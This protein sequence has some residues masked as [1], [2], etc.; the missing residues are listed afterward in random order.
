M[1][2]SE[3]DF[4]DLIVKGT[5]E[6]GK[7]VNP[8]P[9]TASN[10]TIDRRPGEDRKVTI[11]VDNEKVSFTIDIEPRKVVALELLSP[12]DVINY[13]VGE[14]FNKIGMA[15][16]YRFNSGE[17]V[18][19]MDLYL[20]DSCFSGFDSRTPV[21]CQIV[22]YRVDDASVSFTVNVQEYK[23]MGLRIDRLPY[24]E[25]FY[26]Y[27]ELSLEGMKIT[28]LMPYGEERDMEYV[29]WE[30][31]GF[32]SRKP[33][34]DQE[35]T[36]RI[37]DRTVSFTVDILPPVE[38]KSLTF[39]D[40]IKEE[41][42][43][44]E[45]LDMMYHDLGATYTGYAYNPVTN[46]VELREFGVN[47][48]PTA[49]EIS[50]FDSSQP[51]DNQVLSFTFGGLTATQTIDIV[52][53]ELLSLRVIPSKPTYYT[54]DVL[55]PEELTVLCTYENGYIRTMPAG[56]YL[57]SGFDSTKPVQDQRVTVSYKGQSD[58]FFIQVLPLELKSIS[59]NPGLTNYYLGEQFNRSMLRVSA[60]YNS[61][62]IK[63]VSPELV[64][65][66][67]FDSSREATGQEVVVSYQGKQDSFLVNILSGTRPDE[68]GEEPGND[69][70][71]EPGGEPGEE[72]GDKPGDETGDEPGDA[73]DTTTT[74]PSGSENTL[75][76]T[77][78]LDKDTGKAIAAVEETKLQEAFDKLDE[79][80]E[81]VRKISIEISTVEEAKAYVAELPSGFLTEKGA[82][83]QL[84]IKTGVGTVTV[85]GNMLAN[86]PETFGKTAGIT[87][88]RGD[89]SALPEEVQEA[90]GDRPIIRLAL[91]LDGEQVNWNNPGAPVTVSIPYTPTEEELK[92]PESIV[93]RYID[94]SGNVIS[95][96]NGR[97]DPE[98]GTVTFT[99]THF[100]YY[101]VSF[102][103]VSF[104]D[105]P[106]DAWYAKAV[107][108]IAAREITLGTGG[109]NF[110]PEDKLTRGQFIVMM[111]RAYGIAPDE[112]PKD[113]FK[114]AGNTW[115]TG[116]LAAAKRLGISAG[117][118][119]N[120]FAPENAITRQEMFTLLYNGLK[121][122]E[123]LPRGNSG[124]TLSDFS[125]AD[126]IAPWAMDAMK[127]LVETGMVS[128]SG[129]KLSPKDTTTRAQ[130][131]QVF[132]NLLSR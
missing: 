125:D 14:S 97:Y 26:Q 128:G 108:F 27:E 66:S 46:N 42:L 61:G 85:P 16:R 2:V 106:G 89:K 126:E 75:S 62:A 90:I 105:V 101:A 93:I 118:G 15:V 8:M 113:N 96:P 56:S 86:I 17:T 33:V 69:P 119:N 20:D 132:Y 40:T 127:L 21:M 5:Y 111:M 45:S 35:V 25:W 52:E 59:V 80:E 110:S 122:I 77:P 82:E 65:I 10:F 87:I 9:L 84:E 37:E 123:K 28:G 29:L 44:G 68:P 12:P 39:R 116:Y 103:P 72:P 131:A 19:M 104:K 98:S 95:V 99:T 130:M 13:Y 94:G 7:V 67:G 114:D 76:V 34:Q 88:G 71:E 31:S 24:R 22:T 78:S 63:A 124:K 121:V 60:H 51:Q 41:Y 43:L 115:Y 58:S 120:L 81:G 91:T 23:L 11:A 109:G 47:I 73:E 38:V 112:D 55:K 129:N 1:G 70:G 18:D 117:V 79:D 57:I 4:S 100:S 74:T 30:I 102:K 50:G 53:P 49:E 36:I 92:N 54:G 107:S 48:W 3:N 32:D 64:Q 6:N 83:I